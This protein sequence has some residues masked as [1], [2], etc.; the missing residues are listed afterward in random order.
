MNEYK[1]IFGPVILLFATLAHAQPDALTLDRAV[2]IAIERAPQMQARTAA[3]ESAQAQAVSAGRLPDP[4]LVAGVENLPIDTADRFSLTRDFMTMRKVGLMQTF[5][6]HDKRRLQGERA[7]RAIGVAQAELQKSEF[8]TARATAEAWIACAVAEQSLSR[9]REIKPETDLQAEAARAAL[10]S[11]RT[12]TSEA[13]MAQTLAARLDERILALEQDMEMKRAELARW[14]GDEAARPLAA[15]P[16]DR[17]IEH[18]MESL[19]AGVPEHAPLAPLAARLKA[20]QTDVELARAEKKPDWSTELSY[21]KRGAAFSDMVSLEFRIGLPLFSK[22][23]Q[24]PVIA[25]KLAAV[26]A[27]EAEREAEVR[28]HT[29]EVQ[30]AFTQWRRGR[31]RAQQYKNELLPLARDRS[32]AAT[33]SYS[34]GRGDLRGAVNALTEEINTQLEYVEL[35]AAVSRAWAFLHLLHDSE[36]SK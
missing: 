7:E 22:H 28:M 19:V 30:T 31:E 33:A 14:I 4:E 2:E 27:E 8:E 10:S 5:P 35:Q 9:L 29:A 15:L 32:R 1:L 23:R 25:G 13:L 17:T 18:S 26:R 3:L 24:D 20:A 16:A 12:A 6:N 11:G 34:A 36:D 21:A